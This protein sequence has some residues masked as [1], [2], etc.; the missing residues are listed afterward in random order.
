M[1]PLSF[2]FFSSFLSLS[3]TQQRVASVNQV[4][5]F[6]LA[7]PWL[8]LMMFPK[9]WRGQLRGHRSCSRLF[10]ASRFMSP[11][12]FFSL[13]LPRSCSLSYHIFNIINIDQALHLEPLFNNCLLRLIRALTVSAR[14]SRAKEGGWDLNSLKDLCNFMWI[15]HRCHGRRFSPTRT[16]SSMW[17]SST[18]VVF[19][20]S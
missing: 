18:C 10:T 19:T 15:T 9:R 17:K 6:S 1:H 16:A 3:V 11:A 4:R 7:G 20:S 13:F 5:P 8:V 14:R 2:C 12:L